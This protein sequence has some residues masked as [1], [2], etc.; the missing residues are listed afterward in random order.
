MIASYRYN[1]SKNLTQ[2]HGFIGVVSLLITNL[3]GLNCT[4]PWSIIHWVWQIFFWMDKSFK[5][6]KSLWVNIL[7][8]GLS[9]HKNGFFPITNSLYFYHLPQ[10]YVCDTI[11]YTKRDRPRTSSHMKTPWLVFEQSP[12]QQRN[13]FLHLIIWSQR[14]S[15]ENCPCQLYHLIPITLIPCHDWIPWLVTYDIMLLRN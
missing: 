4:Y 13:N 2:I 14:H 5:Q 9:L 1:I 10:L 15:L 7:S 6:M 3:W 12:W 8:L 11:F